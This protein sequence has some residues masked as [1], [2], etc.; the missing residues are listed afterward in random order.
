MR[1][2]KQQK[3]IDKAI[4][5]LMNYADGDAWGERQRQFFDD[6]FSDAADRLQI[7]TEELVQQLESAGFMHMAFRVPL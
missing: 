5:N 7:A 2:R 1:H 3:A 4:A 6:A